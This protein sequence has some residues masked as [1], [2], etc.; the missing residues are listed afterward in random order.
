MTGPGSN[1]SPAM[2][3][4]HPSPR[5]AWRCVTMDASSI[6]CVDLGLI[7]RAQPA[8]CSNRSTSC[9]DWPRSSLHPMRTRSG[10]MAVSPTARAPASSCP[11][12]PCAP[13]RRPRRTRRRPRTPGRYRPRTRIPPILRHRPAAGLPYPGRNSCSGSSINASIAPGTERVTASFRITHPFHPLFDRE[14]E[15]ICTRSVFGR[16]RVYFYQDDGRLHT[17]DLAWTDLAPADTFREMAGGRSLFRPEDLVR[18]ALL[19]EGLR[20]GTEGGDGPR[21][22]HHV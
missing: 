19:L 13:R 2:A 20:G 15:L 11:R 3:C 6:T 10:T 14:I 18:L 12:R 8:S 7:P 22:H 9:A 17:V 16:R 1:D 5:S 4:G 21:G